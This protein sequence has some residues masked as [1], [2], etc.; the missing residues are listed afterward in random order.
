LKAGNMKTRILSTLLMVLLVL[1][2]SNDPLD[3][4]DAENRSQRYAVGLSYA[5]VLPSLGF[6]NRPGFGDANVWYDITAPSFGAACDGST[7]DTKAIAR[8]AAAALSTGGV[9]YI[10]ASSGNRTCVTSLSAFSN[11]NTQEWLEVVDDNDLTITGGTISGTNVA[12]IGRANQHQGLAGAF[13]TQPHIDWIS[14]SSVSPLET[15]GLDGAWFEGIFF[16]NGY[17]NTVPPVNLHTNT[18]NGA[19]NVYITFKGDVMMSGDCGIAPAFEDAPD[20]SHLDR[21]AGFGIFFSG[22]SFGCN[23]AKNGKAAVL[24]E[25]AGNVNT[26][27]NV[28]N[29]FVSG[30]LEATS[31]KSFESGWGDFHISNALSEGLIGTFFSAAPGGSNIANVTLDGIQIADPVG[32][33]YIYGQYG[34]YAQ[35]VT[36]SNVGD[37]SSHKSIVDPGSTGKIY[38]FQCM[39]SRF[40]AGQTIGGIFNGIFSV[41]SAMGRN[42]GGAYLGSISTTDPALTV[43]SPNFPGAA[44]KVKEGVEIGQHLNQA[45]SNDFAGKCAMSRSTSC[46][47]TVNA[48]YKTTP[49]CVATLQGTGE[50]IAAECSASGKTVTITAA[51]PNSGTWAAFLFGDP[52]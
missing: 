38:G 32:P 20:S 5:S 24:F 42:G 16:T 50:V 13:V 46:T 27:P 30:G 8:A 40:C 9:V 7:D 22:D 39:Q 36:I 37:N 6:Q 41:D 25:N 19:G 49:G 2:V 43:D 18:R 35:G 29:S 26:D 34:S 12:I 14:K 44:L 11:A 45:T 52:N 23:S 31:T 48:A 15:D 4:S 21:A 3:G 28:P 51:S 1:A 10:P 17:H 47:F 33:T